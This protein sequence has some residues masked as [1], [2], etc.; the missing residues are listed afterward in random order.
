MPKIATDRKITTVNTGR[1]MQKFQ[2]MMASVSAIQSSR[3][4]V[5]DAEVCFLHSAEFRF[6]TICLSFLFFGHVVFLD[7]FH[8]DA[9]GDRQMAAADNPVGGLQPLSNFGNPRSTQADLDRAPAGS[10]IFND[11]GFLASGPITSSVVTG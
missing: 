1:L 3:F 9:V 6:E 2:I 8:R 7:Y 10:G 4:S 5:C 11:K